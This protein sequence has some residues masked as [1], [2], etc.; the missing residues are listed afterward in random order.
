MKKKIKI[1]IFLVAVILVFFTGYKMYKSFN[2]S[3][4]KA[5][6]IKKIDD[7]PEYGYYIDSNT[8]DYYKELFSELKKILSKDVIDDDEYAKKV[9]QLFTADLF[10]LSTKITSSD[11]GGLQY[12]YN[13]FQDDFVAIAQSSLYMSVKS[14][15]YGDREQEL[16]EVTKVSI[17][18][19]KND[20]FKIG[21]QNYD[22]AYYITVEIEYKKDL[23][24]QSKY[25]LV[26]IKRDNKIE[27]VKAN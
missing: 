2:V 4:P 25:N 24:Y 15:V 23:E 3:T 6:K 13:D 16:P 5:K 9:S 27:V 22:D 14:N 19:S 1:V 18:D 21:D 20:V 7:I 10:T 8:T 12:V 11:I 26:L 17:L